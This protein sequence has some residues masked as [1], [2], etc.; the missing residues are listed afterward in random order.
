MT[1]RLTGSSIFRRVGVREGTLI[2]MFA[3]GFF[4]KL[5]QPIVEK[6]RKFA[7]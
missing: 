4:L 2:S 1:E 6:L 3:V 7:R 5:Y